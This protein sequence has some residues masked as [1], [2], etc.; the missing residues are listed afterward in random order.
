MVGGSGDDLYF[1]D[2]AGDTIVEVQNEG[3]DEARTTVSYT[4]PDWVNDLTLLAGA[5][6]G[7][8]NATDNVI[9]GNSAA[10]SLNGADGADTLSGGGGTDTL[11]GGSGA[12]NFLFN[13]APGTGNADL[14]TDFASGADRIQLDG[15]VMSALG[16]SGT[17]TSGDARFYAAAGV[18]SG[19]DADD[20]VVY[21]TA[22]GR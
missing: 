17:L 2:N 4:L 20:R 3:L 6:N 13:V 9:T 15:R 16:S 22:S 12:D 8:G 11:T 19:H 14:I 10:N 1:V 7:S 5:F 21:D 18:T